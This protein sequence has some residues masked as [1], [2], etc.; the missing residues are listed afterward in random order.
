MLSKHEK[1]TYLVRLISI[2][3]PQSR[4]SRTVT[5]TGD[6]K[7]NVEYAVRMKA[8]NNTG[9]FCYKVR[10]RSKDYPVCFKAS[11]E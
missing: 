10:L 9:V 8:F 7:W 3:A 11:L 1:G 5:D 2:S 4:R 6:N